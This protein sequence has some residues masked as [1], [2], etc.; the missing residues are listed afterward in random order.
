MGLARHALSCA[1]MMAPRSSARA[2]TACS[3]EA[4]FLSVSNDSS[5]FHCV[6]DQSALRSGEE[7]EL[8]LV[9]A[10]DREISDDS[11]LRVS[12]VPR[13]YWWLDCLR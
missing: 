9:L 4:S 11:H 6:A 13:C 12:L 8:A 1:G 10:S 2:V 3:A 7:E 5:I